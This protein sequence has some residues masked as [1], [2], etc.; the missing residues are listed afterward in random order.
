MNGSFIFFLGLAIVVFL[1]VLTLFRKPDRKISDIET[2]LQSLLQ[3]VA[4]NDAGNERMEMQLRDW[5]HTNMQSQDALRN[6][7]DEK[8]DKLVDESRKGRAELGTVLQIFEGQLTQRFSTLGTD[9]N[10]RLLS[11]QKMLT[12]GLEHSRRELDS[13][14]TLAQEDARLGRG[15]LTTA[16]VNL[17]AKL[18][19][20]LGGVDTSLSG[21][22]DQLQQSLQ[23]RLDEWSKLQANQFE[24]S[25]TDST[26]SRKELS[27]TLIQFRTDL[28][29]ALKNLSQETK[30]SRESLAKS[31]TAFEK[32]IQERFDSLARSI[33]NTL[34][35]LK[36]DVHF[37]LSNMSNALKNQLDTN[38]N[39][40]QHQFA[41]LQETV[42]QQLQMMEKG[43]QQNSEQLRT[44][45]NERLAAIQMD[46]TAKLEEMR[47]TVD[48]KLHATLEQRL[49]DSFKLVSD[50]LEQVHVGLG[51]MKSLANSVGN[52]NRVM[53][54]VRT[55]G[56]WGETQLGAIIENLL[57]PDQYAK[58]VKTNQNSNDFVEF[59]IKLPGNKDDVVWLPIDSKYPVE[60]YERLIEAH[61]SA[62]KEKIQK[63]IKAFRD[64]LIQEAK[65]IREK[66][67]N[68][69]LSTDYAVLFVPTEGLFAEICKIPGML[70]AMQN[71]FRVTVA[72]PT[73]LAALLNSL[74]LGFRTIAIEKRS[75]E[76]QKILI[77]VKK[78]FEK[79]GTVVE[80]TQ[81][82]IDQ[83][84]K[85][86]SEIG[87]RT[88][89][90]N[91][92]LKD[93][94]QWSE[95]KKVA[96]PSSAID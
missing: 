30:S 43:T 22:F 49:G 85:K 91:R 53:T 68:P 88:K 87:T 80:A 50:R 79:F 78:E 2:L 92:Q 12:E 89:A 32:Q 8:L 18:E 10:D 63:A 23:N 96:G 76:V 71:E 31:S 41:T 27:E 47:R 29:T 56:T 60:D 26:Q 3:A 14:L 1:Q 5:V 61:E 9:M 37:Q 93:V 11:L 20:R 65:K 52:L 57:T 35:T 70:E 17:E 83:A 15:E 74:R 72:G 75:A 21:R 55:R 25:L 40:I 59:A 64:S 73:T 28:T 19:Q 54:N 36:K 67:I 62:D 44:T 33:N 94:D 34:E 39:Q 51:E 13:K 38:N 82:S 77:G 66:Y 16:F 4:R 45:L 58:N 90:V 69:P 7:L 46:N 84:A 48:E 86:F 81:K 24:R 6:I 42:A 95:D